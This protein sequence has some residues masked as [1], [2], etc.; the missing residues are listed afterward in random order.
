MWLLAG[1]DLNNLSY[2]CLS[3]NGVRVVGLLLLLLLGSYSGGVDLW[4][5]IRNRGTSSLSDKEV[6]ALALTGG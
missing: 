4:L 5:W 3:R 1:G 2:G 6:L